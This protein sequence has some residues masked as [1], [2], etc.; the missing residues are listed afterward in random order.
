MDVRRRLR[1]ALKAHRWGACSLAALALGAAGLLSRASFMH[2]P[3]LQESVSVRLL[4]AIVAVV[5]AVTPLYPVFTE[6]TFHWSVN[7]R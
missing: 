6:L 4:V 7:V 3:F 2:L 5:V 1:P